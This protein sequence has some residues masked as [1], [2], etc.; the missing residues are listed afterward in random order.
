MLGASLELIQD[1]VLKTYRDRDAIKQYHAEF[2]SEMDMERLPC[3]KFAVNIA[4]LLLRIWV[5][6]LLKEKGKDMFFA[7]ALGMKKATRCPMK[8]VIR[9]VMRMCG[10]ITRHARRPALRVDFWPPTN[11]EKL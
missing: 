11:G 1:E 4:F 3:G 8:T 5:Y 6:N 10:R 9:S 2:K 7:R